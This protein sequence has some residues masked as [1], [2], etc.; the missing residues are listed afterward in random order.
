[1]KNN[2]LRFNAN[3]SDV[4]KRLDIF[5]NENINDLT[6][7]NLKKFVDTKKVKINNIIVDAPS[8]K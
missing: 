3:E 1:M 2:T 6:R 7:S 5:L 4:G 8:K